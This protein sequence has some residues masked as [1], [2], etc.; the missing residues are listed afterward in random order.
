MEVRLFSV[1]VDTNRLSV[2]IFKQL[3][4]TALW[5]RDVRPHNVLEVIGTVRYKID[6]C[7]FWALA[8]RG[9]CLV[10][11]K[12][13]LHRRPNTDFEDELAH[14][15]KMMSLAPKTRSHFEQRSTVTLI[16]Q[17]DEE[18]RYKA[19]LAAARMVQLFIGLK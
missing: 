15:R 18:D 1:L 17:G 8:N 7:D 10:R 5:E 14:Y 19:H 16:A 13:N 9:D 3:E 12:L 2:G 4:L 6:N 11:C